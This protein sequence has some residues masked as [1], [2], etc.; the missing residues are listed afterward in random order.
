MPARPDVLDRLVDFDPTAWDVPGSQAL[1]RLAVDDVG[2]WDLL[3]SGSARELV[4]A[5][6]K[7]RRDALL[8]A[9]RATWA[10]SPA[11]SAAAWTRSA[12]A[13]CRSATT[14]TSAS[15]SSPPRAGARPGAPAV[16]ARVRPAGIAVLRAGAGRPVLLLHGLGGTKGSFLPTVAALAT[17][18]R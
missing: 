13:A 11:T 2:D 12:P 16:R 17:P 15:A 18:T 8:R 3:V 7:L 10:R 9:D 6:P 4:P 14:C 1:I 5:E